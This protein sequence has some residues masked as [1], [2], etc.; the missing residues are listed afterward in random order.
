VNTDDET[1]VGAD[2]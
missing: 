2:N 1:A